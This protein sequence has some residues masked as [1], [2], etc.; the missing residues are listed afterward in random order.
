MVREDVQPRAQKERAQRTLIGFGVLLFLTAFFFLRDFPDQAVS[1]WNLAGSFIFAFLLT[2][3]SFVYLRYNHRSVFYSPHKLALLVTIV[4]VTLILAKGVDYFL[5]DREFL[6]FIPFAVFL[7]CVLIDGEIAL[8]VTGFLTL[9]FVLCLAV[10]VDRFI[11]VNVIGALATIVSTRHLHKHKEVFFIFGKVFCACALVVIAFHLFNGNLFNIELKHELMIVLAFLLATSVITVAI[12]PILESVF[13][14]MTDMTLMDYWDPNHPLL[15]RLSLEAPGTY[16]HSL[17]IGNLAESAAQVIGANGLFCRVASLYHDIGKLTNP[18]YFTENQL[19]GFNIHP[20]LTPLESA[21]VIIAHVTEGE[22]LAR[23][24]R[25]P[26]NIIDIIL[27]H[28]GTTLV[29]YFYCK[30]VE[31]EGKCVDAKLFRYAGPR[32]QSKESA[33]I[34]IAD[35]IEA[36]SR[37]LDEV[38]EETLTQMVERLVSDRINDHQFDQCPLSFEELLLVK[39]AI[40]KT[41]AVTSHIRIKYPKKPS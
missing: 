28:H 26:Q 12:L 15:R 5:L 6:V 39:K 16:Q 8:F 11:A 27:Q 31:K 7:T 36:A 38:T 23:K 14:V 1:L 17:V 25:L 32:P 29:Y 2:L 18:H 19:G 4:L 13:C 34:M 20:L 30:Q 22:A 10:P 3:L 33:I 40:I 37:S 24:Y 41:L 35:T 9:I 21:Q